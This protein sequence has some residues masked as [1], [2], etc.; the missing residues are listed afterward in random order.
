VELR[1]DAGGGVARDVEEAIAE[2][3]RKEAADP[4]TENPWVEVTERI[5]ESSSEDESESGEEEVEQVLSLTTPGGRSRG[6]SHKSRALCAEPWTLNPETSS[7]EEDS[8]STR[9]DTDPLAQNPEPHILVTA[10]AEEDSR[11]RGLC[12]AGV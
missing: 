8:W 9:L 1:T 2:L 5:M 12:K 11:S 4:P 6:L 10:G 7:V 3:K